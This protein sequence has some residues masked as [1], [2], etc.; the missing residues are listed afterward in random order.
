MEQD[1]N[2]L[3]KDNK[4]LV[5]KQLNYMRLSGDVEAE[6][7]AYEA[8]WRAIVDYDESTG[9]RLSTL[10][11]VYIYNALGCYLR[12]L[13]RKRQIKTVSY[14]YPIQV[15]KDGDECEL[16]DVLES[17]ESIEGDYIMKERCRYA[18]AA[19]EEEYSK[20]KSEPQK[21]ILKYWKESEFTLST[22]HIAEL[23]GV[24]Q[25]YVSRVLSAFKH[26]LKQR[27]TE[28]Y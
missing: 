4:G 21:A 8:L 2:K 23:A 13:N 18:L 3:I 27:F 11:T 28:V 17:D 14:N 16:L 24:S 10:A 26:R 22:I 15:G 1:I 25:S 5:Y 12:T 19:F 7:L 9:Y 6:S 20:L